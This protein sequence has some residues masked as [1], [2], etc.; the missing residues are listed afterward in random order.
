MSKKLINIYTI[1]MEQQRDYPS[2][3]P[4]ISANRIDQLKD[5]S[6]NN[7]IDTGARIK[8]ITEESLDG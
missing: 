8:F 4:K 5:K 6:A 1:G 7:V 2:S 3:G